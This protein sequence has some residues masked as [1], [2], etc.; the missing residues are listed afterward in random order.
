MKSKIITSL[1]KDLNKYKVGLESLAFNEKN[2]ANVFT[3]NLVSDKGVR[4]TKLISYLTSIYEGKY[5]FS[6]EKIHY[7]ENEEKYL[8]ELKVEVL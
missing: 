2:S 1:T 5:N 4:I 3:L 6:L 7:D 8:S